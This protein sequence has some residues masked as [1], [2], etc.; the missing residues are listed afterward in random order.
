MMPEPGNTGLACSSA[1]PAGSGSLAAGSACSVGA[2]TVFCAG[3]DDWM[4]SVSFGADVRVAG[5]GDGVAAAGA[6]WAPSGWA[7]DLVVSTAGVGTVRVE[8]EAAGVFRSEEHTSE[9]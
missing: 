8:D 7:T 1:S 6:F 4:A 2:V 5:D 9:L 3:G